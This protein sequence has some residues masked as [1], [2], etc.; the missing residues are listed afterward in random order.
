MALESGF[1]N[2]ANGDRLYNAEDIS[3]YFENILSSGI[4]KRI[5]DCFKV[6]ASSGMTLTVAPGAG[7]IDCHWFR[8]RAAEILTVPTANAVLPRFDIVVAR[9]DLSDSVR[10]ISL[11]VV[12]GMPGDNPAA[13]EPIRTANI[14]DLVL[15]LVYVPAGASEIVDANLTDVRSNSWYCGYVR[16]LVDI[17]IH[18]TYN[19][20]FEVVTS[21]TTRVPIG[22]PGYNADDRLNVYVNGFRIAP[23]AEFTVNVAE[24][25]IDLV[26]A[27]EADTV[28][29]F[30]V[31]RFE[32]AEDLP[33]AADIIAEL[34]QTVADLTGKVTAL[35]ADTGWLD[36]P[37]ENGVSSNAN[38]TARLRR[39]GKSIFLRGLCTGI[40]A[41]ELQVATIP[42]GFRPT[43]GGHAYASFCSSNTGM[44]TRAARMFINTDGGVIFRSTGNAVPA[45]SDVVT[46]STSWLID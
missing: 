43:M 14:Y 11:M 19:S 26:E 39:V 45:S 46:I 1:F 12:P 8:A 16:H 2:S 25:Y 42:E 29:D 13:P 18:N 17:P 28:I 27:V 44:N 38:W 30:E 23:G 24:G 37:W 7:L 31:Y 20:R 35:E 6:S 34:T 9:L 15:A 5:V 3:R 22:I 33:D 4:F 41:N 40:T 21:G 10:S 32:R 36:I